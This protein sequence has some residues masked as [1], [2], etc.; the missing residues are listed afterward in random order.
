MS[1]NVDEDALEPW[2]GDLRLDLRTYF[3]FHFCGQIPRQNATWGE[4][5][6]FQFTDYG[7]L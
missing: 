7:A 5:G 1:G 6:L 4:K 2:R 3:G